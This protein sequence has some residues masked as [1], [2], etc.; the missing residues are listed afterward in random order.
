MLAVLIDTAAR[1]GA[2]AKLTVKNFEHD[3]TQCKLRFEEKG[4]K[5]REIPVRHDLEQLLLAYI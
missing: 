4:G 2:V 5:T 3:G 1:V